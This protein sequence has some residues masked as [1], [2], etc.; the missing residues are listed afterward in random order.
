VT[1]VVILDYPQEVTSLDLPA[2]AALFGRGNST[3]A[4]Q[5]TR[6]QFTIYGT[7]DQMEARAMITESLCDLDSQGRLEFKPLFMT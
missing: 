2:L 3:L 7:V 5:E 6:L 4:E 1:L